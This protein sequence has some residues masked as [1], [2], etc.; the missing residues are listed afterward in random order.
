MSELRTIT[1][2]RKNSVASIVSRLRD[3]GFAIFSETTET[4]GDPRYR[5]LAE[6]DAILQ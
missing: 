5:L 2:L 3:E 4:S 1:G 6:P